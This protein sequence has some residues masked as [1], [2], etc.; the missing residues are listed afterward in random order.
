MIM[1]GLEILRDEFN[2]ARINAVQSDFDRREAQY[3]ELAAEREREAVQYVEDEIELIEF[4][5]PQEAESMFDKAIAA[6]KAN[7]EKLEAILQRMDAMELG[8]IES[9]EGIKSVNDE[10]K[11]L[12]AGI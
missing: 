7:T 10:F 8:I 3:E 2:K 6:I 1:S 5:S 9:I 12:G 4:K 11:V